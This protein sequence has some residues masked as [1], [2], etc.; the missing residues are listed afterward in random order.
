MACEAYP[1]G[2]PSSR[3]DLD[4]ASMMREQSLRT[5]TST[6]NRPDLDAQTTYRRWTNLV[7]IYSNCS[8]TV[9]SDKMVAFSGITQGFK[10]AYNIVT[11]D[12]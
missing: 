5:D 7:E 9:L 3:L 8:L 11:T 2:V 6:A 10:E 1:E 4:L 12:R